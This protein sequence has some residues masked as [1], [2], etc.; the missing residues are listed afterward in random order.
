[1]WSLLRTRRWIAFTALV[2]AAIAAFGLLSRWQ[3]ERAEERRADRVM[4]E[5]EAAAEPIA[6]SAAISQ[7]VPWQPVTITGEYDGAATQ[8]IRQRPLDGRN[9]FWVATPLLQPDGARIWVNRGWVPV[10]GSATAAQSPPP[11]PTGEVTVTGWLRDAERMP[12][13]PP[14]DLP[15]GQAAALDPRALGSP[16]S[17][18]FYVQASQSTPRESAVTIVAMPVIDEGRN[19]SYAV[20]WLLFAAVAI[21]GWLFFLRREARDDAARAATREDVPW[22]SA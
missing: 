12:S 15:A 13:P 5:A 10:E 7:P 4:L 1:M 11:V 8:L 9:G 21:A 17:P 18:P 14:G 6:W 16:D 3:W 20:Q 19:I 2:L 22:T